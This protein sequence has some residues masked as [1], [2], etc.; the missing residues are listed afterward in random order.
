MSDEGDLRAYCRKRM[1]ER[2]K[3]FRY[4]DGTIGLKEE[5]KKR[6]NDEIEEGSID[7]MRGEIVRLTKAIEALQEVNKQL[8]NE[9]QAVNERWCTE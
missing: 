6:M 7:W 3:N 4:L 2:E 9:I 5:D 1:E 8:R